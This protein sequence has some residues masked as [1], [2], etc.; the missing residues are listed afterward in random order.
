LDAT[1]TLMVEDRCPLLLK[2]F[3]IETLHLNLPC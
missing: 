1:E 3:S 2:V